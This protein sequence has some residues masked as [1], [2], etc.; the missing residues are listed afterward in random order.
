MASKFKKN[1]K[2]Q[3]I[4]GKDKGKVSTI[5]K[6]IPKDNMAVIEGVAVVKRHTKPNKLNPDGGIIEKEMPVNMS[7]I[8]HIDPKSDSITRI[9]FKMNDKGVKVRYSKKS[10]ELIDK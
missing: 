10:G 5:I 6:V 1:D 8:M 2:V 4:A 3:V 7:K 9:G